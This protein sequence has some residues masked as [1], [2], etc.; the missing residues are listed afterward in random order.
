MYD[1]LKILSIILSSFDIN[2]DIFDLREYFSKY[3]N[4]IAIKIFSPEVIWLKRHTLPSL[5][6]ISKLYLKNRTR[7]SINIYD[8]DSSSL[9]PDIFDLSICFKKSEKVEFA[10]KYEYP[11]SGVDSEIFERLYKKAAQDYFYVPLLSLF[12]LFNISPFRI[13]PPQVRVGPKY[14]LIYS[15]VTSY[16]ESIS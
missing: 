10:V 11:E 3:L 12:S 6:L 5:L 14:F 4:A 8:F 7:I 2:P 15:G 1:S 16:A 9:T 13:I